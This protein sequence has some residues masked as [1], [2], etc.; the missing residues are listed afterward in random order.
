M[1]R[2]LIVD[3]ELPALRFVQNIIE[4]YATVYQTIGTC[5]SGEQALDFLNSHPVDL[6]ITDIS[7]HGMSGIDLARA[8]REKLPDIH[9]LIITGYGEFEY[10]QGAIQ[11]GV[12]DYILK[13]VSI[14]KMTSVLEAIRS[15][16]DDEQ[17]DRASALLPAIACGQPCSAEDVARLYGSKSYRFALVRWGNL[18]MT[19][20]KVLTATSLV[21]PPHERFYVLR[22]RD[23]DERILICPD[24]SPETFLTNLSIYTTQP[25]N[26]ST[27]TA[28]YTNTS[29]SIDR[30]QAF[31]TASLD[32][33]YRMVVIGKH[34]ILQFTG[35]KTNEERIKIPPADLK[36]LGYFVTSGKTRL[37]K[38]YFVSLAISWEKTQMPQRQVWHMCRQLIH[39][40]ATVHTPTYNKL[41]ELLL[42]LNDLIRCANSYSDLVSSVYALLFDDGNMRDKKLSTRE[43]YDYAVQYI[44]DHYPHPLS[45]QSVCDEIGISQTYLSRLFRKYS[46]TTFNAYLT[47]CRMD[48]A[49]KLLREK[50]DLLL[51]DV[52]ACVGYEDSSYFTKVFHQ[53]TG[54]TP[55]QY[56]SGEE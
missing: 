54:L 42:D 50:P 48:A 37:I 4:K 25:G 38:D 35:T 40:V 32:M 10:A 18:D 30:L 27:W 8:A 17:I 20:Q 15:R 22:G 23:D 49:K 28:I 41:E 36:Q 12:D 43:L 5:T 53:Y 33:M 44:M 26:L 55:S 29:Q 46:D 7:M 21:L 19:M 39:Q 3:D 31:I 13:P 6:L 11:A 45:M 24:D 1:Y 47:R 34:Q 9:I 52:A 14:S 16:L 51:R 56:A 2:V